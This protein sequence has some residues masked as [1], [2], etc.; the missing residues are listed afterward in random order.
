MNVNEYLMLCEDI[1][2]H[3]NP[4]YHIYEHVTPL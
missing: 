4:I 2:F 1:R 3:V